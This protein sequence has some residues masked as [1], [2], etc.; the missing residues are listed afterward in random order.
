MQ[1]GETAEALPKL[2]ELLGVWMRV[3]NALSACRSVPGVGLADDS[4][5]DRFEDAAADLAPKLAEI[6]DAINAQDYTA[7]ADSLAYDMP[8]QA[9]AWAELL[10]SMSDHVTVTPVA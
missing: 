7:A 9:E 5:A 2:G 1:V 6:R 4:L 3:D 8:E 10:R